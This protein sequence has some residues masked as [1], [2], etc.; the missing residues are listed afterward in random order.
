LNTGWKTRLD[1][2]KK[3]AERKI[4][5]PLR[6]HGW[7]IHELRE[8]EDGEYLVIDTE[9][10]GRRHKVALLYSPATDN[11]IYQRLAGEVEHIFSN[12]GLDKGGFFARGIDKPVSVAED[13][14]VLL[15][16][17]NAASADGKFA[18]GKEVN[19]D[20]KPPKDRRLLSETPIEAIWLRLR[21]LGSVT[22]AR[23]LIER[24]TREAGMVL[25]P[26]VFGAKA[27]GLA[28]ALRNAI[29]YY[30]TP[31]RPNI[32]QRVLNLYYGSLAF[33][34]AEM[35][36][37]PQGCAKLSEIEDHTKQGHGLFTIDGQ[38]DN[39]EHLVVGVINRGFF[40]AWMQAIGIPIDKFPS[41][42]LRAYSELQPENGLTV[43]ELF[44]RIPEVSDLFCDIF[45]SKPAW[46]MPVYDVSANPMQLER[47]QQTNAIYVSLIDES[48]RL[49]REDI[50]KFPGPIGEIAE[51][52]S[53]YPGRHFRVSVDQSGKGS[54]GDALPLHHSPFKHTT[55]ILPIFGGVQEYRAICLVLLYALSIVV[56]YRPSLW[57]RVQE[58][59]LDHMRVLIEAFLTVVERVLPEEFLEKV[60]GQRVSAKQPGSLFS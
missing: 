23:K 3:A 57:R 14:Q 12:G 46:V 24:R 49:T 45:E 39:L 51:V 1:I 18:P 41:K 26:E 22:L 20:A 54:W 50:A 13:F 58:G 35:L 55:L 31:E 10:G 59:N 2:L 53:K 42:K 36:A 37:L 28:Y 48:T 7:T 9:R 60:T 17:W 11:R 27:E 5:G 8:V 33:A 47:L 43:E 25:D 21:Q 52:P 4:L 32:S 38:Y 40:P 15:V 16:K 6:E 29:D 34:S 44:A 30:Q 19:S 56:R